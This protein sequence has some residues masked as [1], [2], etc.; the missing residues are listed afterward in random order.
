[1]SLAIAIILLAR[2]TMNIILFYY[3]KQKL[4]AMVTKETKVTTDAW[5]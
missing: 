4:M 3:F 5:T 1:M 2:V